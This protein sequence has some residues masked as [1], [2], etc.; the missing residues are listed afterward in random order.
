FRCEWYSVGRARFASTEKYQAM[1]GTF[2]C[3]IITADA[4]RCCIFSRKAT[5]A[6]DGDRREAEQERRRVLRQTESRD[7][8]RDA[9]EA[10]RRA[11]KSGAQGTPQ[12]MPPLRRRP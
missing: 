8:S 12:Q 11:K 10:R 7:H 5:R 4:R 2:F 1:A 9:R 3:E 6:S